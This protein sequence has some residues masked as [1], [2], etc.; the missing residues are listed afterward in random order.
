MGTTAAARLLAP[1]SAILLGVLAGCGG[2]A[3]ET[4]STIGT[5]RTA[6]PETTEPE[7]PV[8]EP[9]TRAECP[10]LSAEEV[11]ELNDEQATEVRIDDG[12]DPA[13]CFFYGADEAVQLTTT[14]HTVDS[15][16]R[17]AQLVEESAPAAT[18]ERVEA[19][20]GWT[21]GHS[22]GPGGALAVLANGDRVLA[23]QSI[24]EQS[25]AVRRV[26]ELVAPRLE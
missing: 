13:A 14:V 2:S 10:Y 1:A 23:V 25:D 9:T 15:A 11:S 22:G 4:E 26:A 21:G 7:I 5:I 16:E 24:D 3:G 17:A 20:G 12:F 19:E 8:A 6:P 18:S